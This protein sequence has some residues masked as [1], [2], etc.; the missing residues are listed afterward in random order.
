MRPARFFTRPFSGVGV[1]AAAL[2]LTLVT[3]P[4]APASAPTAAPAS[5]SGCARR[6]VTSTGC[7]ATTPA[8]RG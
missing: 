8:R 7:C 3:A 5:P 2:T 6:A 4:A 1:L